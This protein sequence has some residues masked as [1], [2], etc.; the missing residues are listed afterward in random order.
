MSQT[1]KG[2]GALTIFVA[3]SSW[4]AFQIFNPNEWPQS[5]K[6]IIQSCSAELSTLQ[7]AAGRIAWICD[8]REERCAH[9]LQ[10]LK[11]QWNNAK[12]VIEDSLYLAEDPEL[13]LVIEGFFSSIK[14]LLDLIVQLLSS[15]AIVGAQIHA[16]H[17]DGDTIGGRVL[18]VLRRNAKQ[19]KRDL[20]KSLVDLISDH[21]QRW[22]DEVIKTRD[23]LIHPPNGARQVMFELRLENRDGALH[24][25]V[26]S[27]SIRDLTIVE[28]AA[29]Q[30]QNMR[31]FA[32]DF[33]KKMRAA[34]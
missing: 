32:V 21:K 16:F 25:D 11:D 13:H 29:R 28:Y 30:V 15:E 14:T 7:H 4:H 22:I 8:H 3:P 20:A 26:V 33:L 5:S 34:T 9:C 24:I 1:N 10:T 6:S 12:W 23:L 18:K 19:Q 17:K 27:P 31:Q 2:K